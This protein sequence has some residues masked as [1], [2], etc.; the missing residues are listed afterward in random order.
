MDSLGIQEEK[1]YP[2][3]AADLGE[4]GVIGKRLA[5]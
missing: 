5:S 4:P 3:E 2:P 1:E